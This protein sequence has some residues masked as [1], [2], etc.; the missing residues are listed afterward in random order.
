MEKELENR[1]NVRLVVIDPAGSYIGR[2]GIDD[3]KDSELRALLDPLA[4]VA[5]RRNVTIILVKHLVKGATARAVHKVSGSAGYVNAV[6]AAFVIAPASDNPDRKLFL[7]LKFNL[8]PWPAGLAYCLD[9]LSTAEAFAVVET[10]QHL[11]EPDRDRLGEQLFRVKWVGT[12]DDDA[13]TVLGEA[14]RRERGGASKVKQAA[15]WLVTFLA[16]YAYPS[17]EVFEAGKAAGFTEDNLYR[18]KALLGKKRVGAQNLEFQ[19]GWWWGLGKPNVWT[20]R[21]VAEVSKDSEL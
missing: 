9:P 10:F 8:G 3:H 15:D 18:A 12:V 16:E 5:A 11:E 1:P 21:P 6:R 7:P 13:D 20:R 17:K 19:G 2:S 14:A 4:E